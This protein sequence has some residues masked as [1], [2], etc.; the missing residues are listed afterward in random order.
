MKKSC[1]RIVSFVGGMKSGVAA[2]VGVMV[3]ALVLCGMTGCG[4]LFGPDEDQAKQL[5]LDSRNEMLSQHGVAKYVKAV[6]V[7]EFALIK[8]SGN[9]YTGT[10]KVEFKALKGAPASEVIQFK[11]TGTFDGENLL[12]ESEPYDAE[13]AGKRL[14]ELITN[15]AG[16]DL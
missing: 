5:L 16:S 2:V 12:L 1:S 14:E 15:A 9:K 11:L 4:K 3:A 10:A 6:D 13:G 8:E 7:S